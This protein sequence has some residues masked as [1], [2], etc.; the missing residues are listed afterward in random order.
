MAGP[1]T[2]PTAELLLAQN[3][4]TKATLLGDRMQLELDNGHV[5]EVQPDTNIGG[6]TRLAYRVWDP[7]PGTV[8]KQA[9]IKEPAPE[10]RSGNLDPCAAIDALKAGKILRRFNGGLAQKFYR[11]HAASGTVQVA[12]TAAKV[13]SG[14]W[15]RA[16]TDIDSWTNSTFRAVRLATRIVEV[17]YED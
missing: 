9:A 4:I 2:Q 15:E 10:I 8:P 17:G 13:A 14:N 12:S 6:S 5:I 11:Y 1:R 16:G 7:E 3:S